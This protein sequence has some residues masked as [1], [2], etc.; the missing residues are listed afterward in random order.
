M[1]ELAALICLFIFYVAGMCLTG[2]EGLYSFLSLF[3]KRK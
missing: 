3:S 1:V 2:E